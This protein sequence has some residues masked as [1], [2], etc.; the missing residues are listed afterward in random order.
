[1][2]KTIIL[3]L[4]A[5]AV[6]LSGCG[7]LENMPKPPRTTAVPASPEPAA[8]EE[9]EVPGSPEPAAAEET[10]VPESPAAEPLPETSA[11][12]TE[13]ESGASGRGM[14]LHFERSWRDAWDPAE[15]KTRILDFYWDSVQAFSEEAPD[16]AA[17][18]T[19]TMAA[20][21]D[22]WYTGSG[23]EEDA[24]IYGYDTMLG[25]AE[26]NYS[27]SLEYDVPA[28]LSST[29][30]VSALRSDAE[31][32]VLYEM[33]YV[34]LGGAHGSYA[35]TAVCFDAR[36]GEQLELGSLSSDPDALR[37]RLLS[38]MLRLAREDADGY[39]TQQLDLLSPEQYEEAFSAL[40]REGMWYPGTD[41]FH[42]FSSLYELGSYATGTT[43]FRIP[44]ENL[45]DVLD[46]RWIPAAVTDAASVRLETLTETPESSLEIV[47]RV[48]VGGGGEA[49]LLCFEGEARQVAL[50]RT[51]FYDSTVPDGQIFFCGSL[52]DAAVQLAVTF[53]GDL[54]D[55]LLRFT[56]ISGEHLYRISLSG[57]DGSVLLTEYRSTA[58]G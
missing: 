13:T 25:L 5:S 11:P 44:Y 3:F 26:D 49:V 37:A 1:M 12:G 42:V 35:G 4:L 47:D 23:S 20:R 22:V 51:A 17:R 54:A 27:V 50:E 33:T 36:T 55:K 18:I 29:R 39:Y 38:E 15:G 21:Q 58:E 16:A 32:C 45:S 43:D 14:L 7:I 31:I 6:L 30:S 28:E 10:A 8:A 48:V 34:Y 19:E 9:T 41:G 57:E 2:K 46:A 56:D 40:L 53:E 24:N 52:R